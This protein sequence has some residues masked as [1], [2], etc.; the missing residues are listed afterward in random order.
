M[1]SSR[2]TL[3]ELQVNLTEITHLLSIE[4]DSKHGGPSSDVLVKA[5]QQS[6]MS[7]T[8]IRV[9]GMSSTDFKVV[10]DHR[11]PIVVNGL[12]RK[13]QLP[14]SPD[15]LIKEFG[16]HTCTVE[17][18]ENPLLTERRYLKEFLHHFGGHNADEPIWKVKVRVMVTALVFP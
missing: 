3:E 2:F 14:W 5:L 11:L 4:E 17:D 15:H 8:I 13:L 18:C 7:S 9:W 1:P 6:H 16:D 10:L 12:N